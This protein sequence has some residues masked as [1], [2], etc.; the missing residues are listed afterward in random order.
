MTKNHAK[1]PFFK[2]SK[3][4]FRNPSV[5][6]IRRE[7][8]TT[9]MPR[10]SPPVSRPYFSP[11]SRKKRE[12]KGKWYENAAEFLR[13]HAAL[14]VGQR[15]GKMQFFA[16][17]PLEWGSNFFVHTR[18]FPNE[19]FLLKFVILS[20]DSRGSNK[21]DEVAPTPPASLIKISFRYHLFFLKKEY[22]V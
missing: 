19:L 3:R 6:D 9:S 16:A 22:E 1:S 10:Y 7:V 18:G 14:K 5:P 20:R 11:V 21:K 13:C 17:F 2:K 12:G 8:E 4:I 15:K